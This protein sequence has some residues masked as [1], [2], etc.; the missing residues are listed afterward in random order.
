M[1]N[2]VIIIFVVLI[3]ASCKQ[4]DAAEE[5]LGCY[6]LKPSVKQKCVDKLA[7]KYISEKHKENKLYTQSFQYEQEKLGFK[8]FLNKQNLP[9]DYID[10]GVL[11]SNER[12]VYI[13]KCNPDHKYY[14]KFNYDNKVW[15]VVQ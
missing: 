1:R 14:M 10:E 11:Y 7:E 5:Y 9:C 2:K 4:K 12:K 8:H 13:V 3:L 6:A 15:R